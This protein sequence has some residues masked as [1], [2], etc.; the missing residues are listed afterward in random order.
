MQVRDGHGIHG[1]MKVRGDL[2]GRGVEVDKFEKLGKY[3]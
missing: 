3:E 2:G 1:V